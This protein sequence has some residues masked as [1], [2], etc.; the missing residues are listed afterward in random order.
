MTCSYKGT[1][2]SPKGFGHCAHLTPIG[3]IMKGTDGNKWIVAYRSNGSH[4]WI[5]T[6]SKFSFP[7]MNIRKSEP[8]KKSS[9]KSETKK[10]SSKK[11]DTK[12]K[13]KKS[14]TKKKSTK[15][16]IKKSSSKVKLGEKTVKQLISMCKK[17][18][19]KCSGKRK[20]EII[21]ILK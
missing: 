2:P 6:T 5:K 1:E 21:K 18:D 7:T 11:S 19:L 20:S 8:K 4:Y 15:K 17:R 9:K 3:T 10:K 14:E 12:K 16:S 13:S